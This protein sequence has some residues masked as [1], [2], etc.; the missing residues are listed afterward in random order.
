M[1]IMCIFW[2]GRRER[3]W[4]ADVLIVAPDLSA[5]SCGGRGCLFFF[6]LLFLF[7]YGI[8]PDFYFLPAYRSKKS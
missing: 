4:S 8:S 5:R 1:F 2:G 7:I 6:F 3:A